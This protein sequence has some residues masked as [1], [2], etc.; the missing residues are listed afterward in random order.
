MERLVQYVKDRT[1]CFDDYFPCRKEN[2]RLDYVKGWFNY[3]MLSFNLLKRWKDKEDEDASEYALPL[4][5]RVEFCTLI[6]AVRLDRVSGMNPLRCSFCRKNEAFYLRSYEGIGLCHRCFKKN[7]EDRVRRT[8]S[9][10]KMLR[11]DD[12]VAVAVSGGKDSLSLL[13]ILGKIMKRFP[14]SSLKAVTV[15]EG[16]AEYRD[17]AISIAKNYYKN[18]SIDYEIVSFEDLFQMKLDELVREKRELSP[19][20]IVKCLEEELS[21]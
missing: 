1:E 11:R 6:L 13:T 8:I 14:K 5:F 20:P 16:I 21:I 4:Y 17:E 7:I 18:H 10:Y 3:F 9:K 12:H 19:Y 15:D 2:C